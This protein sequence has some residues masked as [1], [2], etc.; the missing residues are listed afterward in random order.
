MINVIIKERNSENWFLNR[1]D[2]LLPS[3]LRDENSLL[4]AYITRACV[5]RINFQKDL[6]TLH[7]MT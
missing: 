4:R 2:E 6:D 7:V 5:D 1:H 3:A